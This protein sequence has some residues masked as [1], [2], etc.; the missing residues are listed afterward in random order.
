[1]ATN[2]ASFVPYYK[3]LRKWCDV[4]V[5]VHYF[6]VSAHLLLQYK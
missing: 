1:L 2:K 4:F 5:S 6:Q 3:G